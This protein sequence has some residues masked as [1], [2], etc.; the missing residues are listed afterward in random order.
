M[1]Q[2]VRD[3]RITANIKKKSKVS[4]DNFSLIL[5]YDQ[6]MAQPKHIDLLYPNFQYGLIMSDNSPAGNDS[7]YYTTLYTDSDRFKESR[8]DWDQVQQMYSHED[9]WDYYKEFPLQ[10]EFLYVH[11][12][13]IIRKYKIELTFSLTLYNHSLWTQ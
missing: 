6:V 5:S 12:I 4:H 8:L 3:D 1:Q 10:C 9:S 7:L 11:A 2:V 13:D